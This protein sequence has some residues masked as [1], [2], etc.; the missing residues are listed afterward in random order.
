[1]FRSKWIAV[2]VIAIVPWIFCLDATAQSAQGGTLLLVLDASGSMW[3]QVDN[4]NKIVIARRVLGNLVDELPDGAEV[5]VIA[6]GHRR[7][8]DCD[9]IETVVSVGPLDRDL[10]KQTV[11]GLTPKGKTP[12]T[13]SVQQA[14]D[15]LS[16]TDRTATV[17]LI[18]DGLETCGGD[19]CAAVRAA[20]ERGVDFILHVVGFDVSGEDVSQLECA[21]QAGNGLF[22]SA[23]N[24][25]DLSAALD[26][27]VTMPAEAP[28]GRLSIKA[29]ADGKLQDAAVQVVFADSGADAGGGRTYADEATNPR[30]I[31]LPD[32]TFEVKVSA[33]GIKGDVTRRFA[34]EITDGGS[35]EKVV[36]FSVGELSIGVTRNGALSDSVYRVVL[37]ETGD[38]VAR[39][40][41]YVSA[42]SNPAT[43][44]VT[45]GTY[46]VLVGSVEIAGKPWKNLGLVTVEPGGRIEVS[47]NWETGTLKVGAVRG[48]ELVDATLNV[49]DVESGTSVGQGRTYT[50]DQSNPKSFNLPPGEYRVD[51]RE[52]RG[53]RREIVVSVQTG[54]ETVKMVE[55]AGGDD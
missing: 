17:I 19:P 31:P 44:R 34:V 46:E 25:N 39:G 6:Y 42:K 18:S 20:K 26:Q 48:S 33:V 23:E 47:H 45:S 36:D 37:P 4:E 30:V 14:F 27:A 13:R 11:G 40:R 24:A 38:E 29:I 10:I 51:I 1:M 5:G 32:G 43:V 52:I 15:I 9:D 28:V 16:E 55:M 21:A 35:V 12:I 2:A 7:E 53:Q 49:I 50:S 8:A 54:E 22:F 41:T 3:G